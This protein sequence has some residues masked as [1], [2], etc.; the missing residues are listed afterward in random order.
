M[1][2]P[3]FVQV[4][5]ITRDRADILDR[6]IPPSGPARIPDRRRRNRDRHRPGAP[7]PRIG[8]PL[9]SSRAGRC[10]SG[11]ARERRGSRAL[12]CR[13]NSAAACRR[14]DTRGSRR[15]P[16]RVPRLGNPR[17]PA[18]K[19][20]PVSGAP[21]RPRRCRARC[22]RG[23]T[24]RRLPWPRG[25]GPPPVPGSSVGARWAAACRPAGRSRHAPQRTGRATDRPR[26]AGAG[27]AKRRSRARRGGSPVRTGAAMAGG[28]AWNARVPVRATRRGPRSSGPSRWPRAATSACRRRAGSAPDGPRPERSRGHRMRKSA[29]RPRPSATGRLR[30]RYP[31]IAVRP[32]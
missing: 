2:G 17:D 20:R 22:R 24:R 32:G 15:K 4:S 30:R 31:R 25:A 27:A 8:A 13:P 18:R 16:R 10:A 21:S 29:W 3:C 6:S 9:H 11:S 14:R 5:P 19:G 12:Q 1:P 26:S 28:R 23:R 7:P